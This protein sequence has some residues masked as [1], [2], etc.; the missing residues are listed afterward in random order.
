MESEKKYG[1]Q[2]PWKD[3]TK[4]MLVIA[5]CHQSKWIEA[6]NLFA[7]EFEDRNRTLETM[8]MEFFLL[9]RKAEAGR[10]CI[11]KQ[12]EAREKIL[13]LLATSYYHEKKWYEAKKFL[14]EL[15]DYDTEEKLR[16]ERMHTVA[17]ISF[18]NGDLEDA[19]IWCTK[20][21]QGRLAILGKR[22]YL[23]YQSVNFLA[24]IYDAKGEFVE[25]EGYKAVLAVL[26]PGLQ[27]N[28]PQ[29]VKLIGR[30]C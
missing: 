21:V 4:R 13:E 30:M 3:E 26:P 25:A 10:I 20:S 9:G 12:L 28:P 19:K 2:F 6:D 24:Q 27:G 7:E 29:I 1:D 22:H 8:A 11:G 5:Y 15:L 17:E 14:I 23:F 18:A 16:L